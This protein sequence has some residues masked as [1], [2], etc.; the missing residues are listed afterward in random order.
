MI[1]QPK[2]MGGLEIRQLR[3]V[4]DAL[5][6]KLAWN[7]CLLGDRLQQRVV[8]QKYG[9]WEERAI[10]HLNQAGSCIWKSIKHGYTV[11]EKGLEWTHENQRRSVP[12]WVLTAN[13]RFTIKS[14]Y[15]LLNDKG[16][17]VDTNLIPQKK[18]WELKGPPRNSLSLWMLAHRLKTSYFL[19]QKNILD[20]P[21]CELC[22]APMETS[23]HTVRDY[24]HQKVIWRKLL[25][26]APWPKFWSMP[27][28]KEWIKLNLRSNNTTNAFRMYQKYV[29]RHV[30]YEA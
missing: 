24:I 8:Q 14:A 27:S 18:I 17:I 4:N 22:G 26:G 16:E 10:L 2:L 12:I 28:S 29:F 21:E 25:N 19:W 5:L 20:S 23:L 15:G 7:L 11:L 6:L 30:V 13:N 9:T 3:R 1:C